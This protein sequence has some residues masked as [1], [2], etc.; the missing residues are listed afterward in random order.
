MDLDDI[1]T[2]QEAARLL[3]ITE[4][5]MRHHFAKGHIACRLLG[6]EEGG[7]MWVTTLAAVRAFQKKRRKPGRP[8]K[9]RAT[10]KGG[11]DAQAN[12]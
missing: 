3:G 2:A 11:A 1:L 5:T 9:P 10:G 6:D 12:P 4:Q 8:R 7:G